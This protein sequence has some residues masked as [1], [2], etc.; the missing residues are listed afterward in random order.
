MPHMDKFTPNDLDSS[1]S[2]P[3]F[4]YKYLSAERVGNVLEGGAVRFTRLLNTNDTFEV[5]STFD[6]LAGPKMLA[7]L[8]EQMDKTLSAESVYRL[9]SDM[10]K[11]NGL[12]FLSPDQA[13][14][15]AE[16]HYGGQFM[17]IFRAQMQK[18]VDILVIPHLKDP[19]N[20]KKLLEHLGSELLCFSLS[21]RMDSPPMWAHYADNNSGFVIAFDTENIWFRRQKNGENTRLQKVTYFDGKLDEPLDDPRAAFVS[22]TTDWSYEREWRLYIKEDQADLTT[23][24]PEDPIH[25]LRFPPKAIN[26]VI[27]GPKTCL[28]VKGRISDILKYRYPNVKMTRAIP[29]RQ[30]HTYEEIVE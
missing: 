16:Q 4:L 2:P 18:A 17:A 13:L 8:S 11:K 3:R 25:L 20:S 21:E 23:G 7:M 26:R 24:N 30:S 5:R 19:Q 29:N 6:T 10:L 27:L 14:Q 22:K 28:E 1:P 9:T 15:I 12:G